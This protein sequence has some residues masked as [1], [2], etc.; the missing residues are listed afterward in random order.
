MAVFDS[1]THRPGLSS[2]DIA[3][4]AG[5]ILA[6]IRIITSKRGFGFCFAVG[7]TLTADA[8]PI[9]ERLL[10]VPVE[11][12]TVALRPASLPGR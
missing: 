7:T 8:L 4:R 10:G 3:W 6:C 2:V 12:G 1:T 9:Q 5:R 11:S